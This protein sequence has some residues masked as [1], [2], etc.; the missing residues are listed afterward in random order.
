VDVPESQ[1]G[2]SAFPARGTMAQLVGII[3]PDTT[4]DSSTYRPCP[5]AV[6]DIA[7]TG[8][9]LELVELLAKNAHDV[10]AQKRIGEDWRYGKKRNDAEKLTPCLVPYEELDDSER[11]YDRALVRETLKVILKLGYR[12]E[13]DGGSL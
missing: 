1:T 12:I 11:E 10:W 2:S 5:L 3:V 4:M 6:H 8:E 13:K 7:L 9:L